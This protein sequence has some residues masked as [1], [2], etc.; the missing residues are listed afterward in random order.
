MA[1][2]R[3]ARDS[4]TEACVKD[5]LA[6]A[7]GMAGDKSM[8]PNLLLI[9]SRHSNPTLREKAARALGAFRD[10][11]TI[12][13]LRAALLDRHSVVVSHCMGD[14]VEERLFPV[15]VAAADSLRQLGIR[16][17]KSVGHDHPVYAPR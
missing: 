6:V 9:L 16:V 2:L 14:V 5:S 17:P 7:L 15:R 12:P 4:A 13:V 10:P 3:A 11:V 8:M 1:D